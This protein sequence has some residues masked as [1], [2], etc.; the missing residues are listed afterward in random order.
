MTIEEVVAVIDKPKVLIVDDLRENLLLLEGILLSLDLDVIS[1]TNGPDALKAA[2]NHDF[3]LILLDV[4]MPVMDGIE[5]AA[6]IR[7]SHRTKFVPIVFVTAGASDEK[8]IF[9][10]Y[11]SGAVDYMFKPLKAEIVRSKVKVFVE[12]YEQKT[13]LIEAQERAEAASAALRESEQRFRAVTSFAQDPIMIFEEDGR[14]SFWNSKAVETFGYEI[15]EAMKQDAIGL[16]FP[17]RFRELARASLKTFTMPDG[18]AFIGA[19]L[20]LIAQHKKGREFPIE[21]SFST[22]SYDGRSYIVAIVRDTTLRHLFLKRLKDSKVEAEKANASK[23]RFLSFISH[24]LRTPIHGILGSSEMLSESFESND[25]ETST[26]LIKT[27]NKSG[28]HLLQMV[29]D[30]LDLDRVNSNAIMLHAE[31][32]SIGDFIEDTFAMVQPQAMVR[33]VSLAARIEASIE[34]FD[35][36]SKRLRQVLL[37]LL[38]NAIKYS[39]KDDTIAVVVSNS[40][41]GSLNWSVQDN[42]VGIEGIFQKSIFEEYFQVDEERD[43]KIGGTGLGLPLAKRLVELQGGEIGVESELGTGS[44]FWFTIPVCVENA[45]NTEAELTENGM[46]PPGYLEGKSVLI[47]DD[48]ETNILLIETILMKSG[49]TISTATNGQEAVELATATDYDIILMDWKMPIMNGDAA[50]RMIRS[51]TNHSRTVI[52]ATTGYVGREHELE[53]TQCGC[54]DYITK[55][56]HVIDL[57]TKIARVNSH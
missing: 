36:D 28:S 18:S 30:L 12:L 14:I 15:D 20:E 22:I 5:T 38:S 49:G 34:S 16:L 47:V 29:N 46:F 45:E 9:L 50:T 2:L 1:V 27:I 40:S 3:A 8:S 11:E 21:A 56:F 25:A 7:G 24:E 44:N 17:D 4:M 35:A 33:R 19:T 43:S 51:L 26:Q 23:S 37:N 6:L 41:S 53:F 48:D 54:T 31:S 10:G 52:I 42:G 39:P 13:R 57:L 55:P 32:I